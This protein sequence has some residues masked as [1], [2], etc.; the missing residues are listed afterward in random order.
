MDVYIYICLNKINIVK[1]VD[2]KF[3]SL[4]FLDRNLLICIYTHIHSRVCTGIYK[5]CMYNR[6]NT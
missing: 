4:N 3:I 6:M 1:V 5:K 2:A